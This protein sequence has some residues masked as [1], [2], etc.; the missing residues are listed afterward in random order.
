MISVVADSAGV[1]IAQ[2]HALEKLWV[3]GTS[4]GDAFISHIAA[5]PKLQDLNIEGTKV[6]NASTNAMCE[7][8]ILEH[9]S[10]WKTELDDGSLQRIEEVIEASNEAARKRLDGSTSAA[11]KDEL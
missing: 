4:I 8:P 7:F 3:D 1:Y 10:G 11:D 9:F 2:L 5:L 6:S